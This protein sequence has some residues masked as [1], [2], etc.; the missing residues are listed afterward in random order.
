MERG[1]GCFVVDNEDEL[2]AVEA[3]AAKRGV[4]QRILLRVTPG[5]DPHTYEAVNT[6]MVDS[7]FGRAIATGEAEELVRLAL[8]MPHIRLLGFHC[9]VG[10]QVFAEDVFE[11]AVDVMLRFIAEMREKLGYSASLLDLGGGYGV[12]YVDSDPVLN[13]AEKIAEVARVFH[14]VCKELS[15]PEPA[16]ALEPGR[17]IVA[18]AGLTL[19][20]A[21]SVKRIAGYKNYVAVDGGM[22]DNPRFALYKS[23]YTVLPADDMD[24]PREL[25]CDVAGCCCE[26]G[27]I[28]Q[29]NVALPETLRR[30][31]LVAVCTTGAYNYAMA[32]NYNRVP[33][34]SVVML[35]DGESY[36][37]VRRESVD[38][39]TDL[40]E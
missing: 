1:V 7:K 11:R 10:S 35:R 31:S 39:L 23:R 20:T 36:V 14:A 34:P 8:S 3:E 37:A 12:R 30:G 40:D 26:S 33:R 28:L 13:I 27:D 6:G 4:A 29:Q 15:L 38:D 17:S 24:A 25:V 22:T 9:H 5:I 32:S 2:R 19:Y 16:V 21:Q 18:D